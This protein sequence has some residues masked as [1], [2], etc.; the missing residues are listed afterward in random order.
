MMAIKNDKKVIINAVEVNQLDSKD[1]PRD[2]IV[3]D[4]DG[5]YE[6]HDK[7][8]GIVSSRYKNIKAGTET[9]ITDYIKDNNLK[10]VEAVAIG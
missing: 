6:R 4:K 5:N 8:T 1:K 9:E 10:V 3:I 7:V 2:V